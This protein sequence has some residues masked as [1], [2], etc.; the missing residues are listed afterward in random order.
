MTDGIG[1]PKEKK[2]GSTHLLLVILI[3]SLFS[4]GGWATVKPSAPLELQHQETSPEL[5]AGAGWV[6]LL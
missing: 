4:V 3:S 6:V 1:G 5:S 2:K